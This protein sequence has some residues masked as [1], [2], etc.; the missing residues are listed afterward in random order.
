M[1]ALVEHVLDVGQAERNRRDRGYPA[2]QSVARTETTDTRP[3]LL[4]HTFEKNGESEEEIRPL[5][6]QVE[7][8]VVNVGGA[9]NTAS[10]QAF[11]LA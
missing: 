9:P 10:E 3:F 5:R 4:V 6:M 11:F 2:N 8:L 1:T 7:L